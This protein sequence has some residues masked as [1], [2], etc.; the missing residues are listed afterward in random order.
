MTKKDFVQAAADTSADVDTTQSAQAM[1]QFQQ[2]ADTIAATIM[3]LHDAV[4]EGNIDTVMQR[5]P[6][7]REELDA[8][9]AVALRPLLE[10][11]LVAV[12]KR[13]MELR[14]H[15]VTL[16]AEVEAYGR[17]HGLGKNNTLER[18]QAHQAYTQK[19]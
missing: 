10:H 8:L 19:H 14:D 15:T 9:N 17:A 18:T 3:A 2:Q 13:M 4:R 12:R 6:K 16:Y 5:W 7:M 1:E 11:D